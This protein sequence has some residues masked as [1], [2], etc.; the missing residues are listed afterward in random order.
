L[1]FFKLDQE[2]SF[3]ANCIDFG[4]SV[5]EFRAPAPGEDSAVRSFVQETPL[6]YDFE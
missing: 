1:P 4:Q 5:I 6:Y 3:E 2:A